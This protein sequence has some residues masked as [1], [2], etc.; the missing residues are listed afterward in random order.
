[1]STS[2]CKDVD[3][4][5]PDPFVYKPYFTS[6]QT[7]TVYCSDLTN[8]QSAT[9]TQ[10]SFT[11]QQDADLLAKQ[12]A[13]ELAR[14]LLTS[15]TNF[16]G[17]TTLS[18]CA[19]ADNWPKTVYGTPYINSGDNVVG[20]TAVNGPAMTSNGTEIVA[21]IGVDGIMLLPLSATTFTLSFEMFSN[22]IPGN[23]DDFYFVMTDDF[24]RNAIGYSIQT[25]NNATPVNDI[26][27]WCN[28]ANAVTPADGN[29]GTQAATYVAGSWSNVTITRVG[30]VLTLVVNGGPPLAYDTSSSVAM[31]IGLGYL[32][33]FGSL[34]KYRNI[35]VT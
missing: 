12:A 26:L 18:G 35:S 14:E 2:E 16:A 6:T 13:E 9:S 10:I 5:D 7:A 21:P 3:C 17:P 25:T 20:W 15:C 24:G 27:K 34:H 23:N 4:C 1:M 32:T 22:G 31:R 29:L 11:S 33:Y 30:T 8:T 28:L 19:L